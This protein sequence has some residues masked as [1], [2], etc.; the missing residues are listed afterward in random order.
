FTFKIGGR[1]I[2]PISLPALKALI[3]EPI[4]VR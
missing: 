4:A 3:A 1:P 2:T